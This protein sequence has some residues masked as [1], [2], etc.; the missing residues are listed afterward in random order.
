MSSG[1]A[2]KS[3]NHVIWTK[4]AVMAVKTLMAVIAVIPIM[5]NHRASLLKL[6]VLL[7]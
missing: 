7:N 6:S 2:V 3:S 4:L 1:E 5:R